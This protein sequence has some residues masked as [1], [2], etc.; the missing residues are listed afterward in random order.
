MSSI[1]GEKRHSDCDVNVVVVKKRAPRRYSDQPGHILDFTAL[2]Q[3]VHV[4][5]SRCGLG[6]IWPLWA[7][8]VALRF[9]DHH[10]IVS[11]S[12]KELIHGVLCTNVR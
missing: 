10:I 8:V 9:I 11:G 4:A 7:A 6:I 3:R 5:L 1:G 2:S 12:E